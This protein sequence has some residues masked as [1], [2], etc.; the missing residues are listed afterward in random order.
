MAVKALIGVFA[1]VLCVGACWNPSGEN[2]PITDPDV[3]PDCYVPADFDTIQAAINHASAGEIILVASGTYSENI[4]LKDG[5][6]LLGEDRDTTIIDGGWV[7]S[8]GC[9]ADTVIDGFTVTQGVGGP[10][11]GGMC[12]ESSIVT[13]TDCAFMY[14]R[15]ADSSGLPTARGGA[16]YNASGTN[17]TFCSNEAVGGV[18]CIGGTLTV[19]NS[20][21][22][23]NNFF[24]YPD[25]NDSA[26]IVFVDGDGTITITYSNVEDGYSGTGNI[27]ADPQLSY[28]AE[29]YSSESHAGDGNS[30][31][32]FA[33]IRKPFVAKLERNSPKPSSAPPIMVTFFGP[34]LSWIIPPGIAPTASSLPESLP[35]S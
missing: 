17:C 28:R 8:A 33:F 22:W 11:G 5:V 25:T 27:D 16:I 20:I 15:D 34:I 23:D 31:D 18:L 24:D 14:N 3:T 30:A 21:L 4:S 12:N 6:T 10:I 1:V 35:E 32:R 2:G 26:G 19:Y 13:L 29:D 9:G 7:Y